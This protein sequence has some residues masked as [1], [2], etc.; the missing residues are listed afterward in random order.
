MTGLPLTN[1]NCKS[2]V[3]RVKVGKPAWPEIRNCSRSASSQIEL[4]ANSEPIRRR[5]RASVASRNGPFS[6]ARR[7][8][9]LGAPAGCCSLSSNA[10]DGADIARFFT[11]EAIAVASARSLRRNFSLAGVARNKPVNSTTVPRPQ[12]AGRTGSFRPLST[13]KAWPED[14]SAV[15]EVMLR[16]PAA[17]IEGSASPLKP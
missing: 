11:V 5:R 2:D 9:F 15:R 10:T 3:P 13:T 1:K 12:A 14:D 17:P 7:K 16:R 4:S 8:T 6:G